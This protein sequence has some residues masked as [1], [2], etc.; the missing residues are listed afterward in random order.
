MVELQ[1]IEPW[2]KQRSHMLSTCLSGYYFLCCM[3]EQAPGRNLSPLSVSLLARGMP[4]ASSDLSAPPGRVA[5]ERSTR[6]TSRFHQPRA[7]IMLIYYDSIKQQER[8]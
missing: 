2:S 5:S 1:G 8:N 7:E 4:Q 3:W 6:E